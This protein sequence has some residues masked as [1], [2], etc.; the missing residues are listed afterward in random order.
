VPH[1]ASRPVLVCVNQRLAH[2][3]PSCGGRGSEAIAQALEQAGARLGVAVVRL[4]CFGRCAEG[5]N[6]R[7]R[8]GRFFRGAT[9]GDVE[10]ILAEAL[11]AGDDGIDSEG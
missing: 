9:L 5:P 11:C 10:A 8:G 7:V 2:A 1:A 3:K 4:K 6:V